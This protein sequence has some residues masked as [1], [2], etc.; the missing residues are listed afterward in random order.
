[1]K[2]ITLSALLVLSGCATTRL[3]AADMCA[4]HGGVI[5]RA[6]NETT[7]EESA[8]MC[9]DFTTYKKIKGEWRNIYSKGKK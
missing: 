7:G 2:W 3:T 4:P 5:L 8:V 9:K 6:W 1:M